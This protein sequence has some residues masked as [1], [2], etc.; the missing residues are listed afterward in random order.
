[1]SQPTKIHVTTCSPAIDW[2]VD[3]FEYNDLV[4]TNYLYATYTIVKVD[5]KLHGI[6]HDKDKA[7][8]EAYRIRNLS[9]MVGVPAEIEIRDYGTKRE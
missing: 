8:T 1:M 5:S 6:Y 7:L 9:E 3:G 4:L 2:R